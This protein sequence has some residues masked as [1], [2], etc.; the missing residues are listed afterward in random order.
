LE[1]FQSCLKDTNKEIRSCLTI[2]E[3]KELEDIRQSYLNEIEL[4]ND[5]PKLQKILQNREIT[6]SCGKIL[7]KFFLII[8]EEK[9]SYFSKLLNSYLKMWQEKF[10]NEHSIDL[11]LK[12]ITTTRFEFFSD[13]EN[14][15]LNYWGYKWVL[16]QFGY[17]CDLEF[18]ETQLK[19]ILEKCELDIFEKN[20]GKTLKAKDNG[21]ILTDFSKLTGYDFEQFIANFFKKMGYVV[22]MTPQ[23]RDQGA[24]LIIKHK[25]DTIVVQVKN[26]AQSVPNSAIQQVVASKKYY[27]ANKA[28][29]IT[30]S[31]FTPAAIDLAHANDVILWDGDKLKQII[32]KGDA[33]FF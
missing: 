25:N 10:G 29:A 14:A 12:E 11:I 3:R 26:Y 30:T 18:I 17:E 7:D 22:D 31:F 4:L 23:S 9:F 16:K 13:D 1:L 21:F 15:V 6:I 33:D 24:D 5:L 32:S 27:K 28:M 20:L 8:Q 19:P 2:D